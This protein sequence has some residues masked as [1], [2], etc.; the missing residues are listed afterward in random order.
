MEHFLTS[1][2]AEL[3]D[4]ELYLNPRDW[5]LAGRHF[6]PAV[7]VFSFSKTTDY[8]DIMFPAWTF[9]EGGPALGTNNQRRILF[10]E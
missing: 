1:L 6:G 2:L 4:T 10:I 5:P 8:W 7:P 3:E 9:W